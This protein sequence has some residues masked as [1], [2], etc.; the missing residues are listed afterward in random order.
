M[1]IITTISA[2]LG[3]VLLTASVA[4]AQD[5]PPTQPSGV[6]IAC[7]FDGTTVDC[8]AAGFEPNSS[9][10]GTVT[11]EG[12]TR[13]TDQLTADAAGA[14]SYTFRPVCDVDTITVTVSGTDANGEPASASTAVDISNC[15]TALPRTGGGAA[16]LGV[17]L[18]GAA[19]TLRR[20]A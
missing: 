19:A 12:Q 13:R 15:G 2:V 16:L 9:V 7:T 14:V 1:R 18:V 4:S 8:D 17:A 3:L 20:R 5:Y 11:A 6:T 10:T